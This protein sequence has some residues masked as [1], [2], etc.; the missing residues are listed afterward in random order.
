MSKDQKKIVCLGGGIGTVHLI[1]GLKEYTD[2]ISVIFSMADDG[3]SAGRLR[4]L[5]NMP[6]PGDVVSCMAA[7]TKEKDP[8]LAQLL[9]YRFPGDRY[10][11]DDELAGHKIGNLIIAALYNMFGNFQEA[12][13]YFQKMFPIKGVFLSATVEPTSIAIHT[14]KGTQVEREEIIDTGKYNWD[15]GIEK[16]ILSPS[17]VKANPKALEAIKDADVI[18]AGPGDL[19]TNL[20]PVLLV[21]D[22]AKA[23]SE[24]SAKKVFVI[25][26]TNKPYETYKYTLSD[27]IESVKKH[28]GNFPFDSVLV[29]DNVAP[30]LPTDIGYEYVT[31]EKNGEG[32]K[33]IQGEIIYKDVI[34]V[35]SPL[36]H[37]PIKLAK[38]IWQA[39]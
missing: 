36:Y 22:L 32:L 35:K 20:L 7:L 30:Q 21:E 13:D 1:S 26:I 11:K 31:F 18:I 9:T 16:L 10:G 15:E 3:G 24:C 8:F 37:D 28:I 34:D 6:P 2:N 23:L 39:V 12:V 38:A 27:Y 29:N 5:Y 19:Y 33:E 14:R 25:N 17:H 4:R